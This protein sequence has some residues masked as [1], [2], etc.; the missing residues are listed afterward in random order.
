VEGPGGG[1]CGECVGNGWCV[2]VEIGGLKEEECAGWGRGEEA[3][4]G[5]RLCG[6]G[7]DVK[8]SCLQAGAEL[9]DGGAV[10]V[11]GMVEEYLVEG[12]RGGVIGC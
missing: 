5:V 7:R 1:C 11:R 8:G 12:L 4:A 3:V 2:K 10:G 6:R 9:E